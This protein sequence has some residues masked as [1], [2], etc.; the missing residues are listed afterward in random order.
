[1]RSVEGH[2]PSSPELLKRHRD[3][4]RAL[5]NEVIDAYGA[6]CVCCGETNRKF[7]TI[8]HVNSDGYAD[9]QRRSL[10]TWLKKNNFPK[11]RY[12]LMCYNCNMGRA[13]NGG[14]CPH[15]EIPVLTAED[16]KATLEDPRTL[17]GAAYLHEELKDVFRLGERERN[18]ILD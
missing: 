18:L 2:S 13:K 17:A 16:V 8:D 12:Q 11:D 10:M 7:L 1:M 5:R 6:R 4:N 14:V 3:Y 9:R 15:K